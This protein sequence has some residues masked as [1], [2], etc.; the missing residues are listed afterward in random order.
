MSYPLDHEKGYCKGHPQIEKIAVRG[1]RD[2]LGKIR[3]APNRV[4]LASF[5]SGYET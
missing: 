1:T 3:R 4:A 2:A 5:L